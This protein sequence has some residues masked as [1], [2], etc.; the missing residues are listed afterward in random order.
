MKT[1]LAVKHPAPITAE[2]AIAARIGPEQELRRTVA[3]CMLWEDGFY[4]SGAAIGDRIKSL[5]PKCRPE[6]VAACAFEARTKMKLRHAPLLLV[7]EMARSAEHRVLVSKLLPDV[8][9]RADE[10]AEF[11][12]LYWKDGKQPLSKQVKTGLAQAFGKF[13]EYQLAKY[14]RDGAVKLR[15]VLFLCHAKA[16]N[17]EQ[18]ALW[19]KLIDGKLETPDTWEVALSGG[20]DKKATFERLMVEGQLGALAFLR[21]LR[22]MREAGVSADLVT[23][24][25][26]AVDIARVLPFRF[27]AAARAVPAWENILEPM[28]LRACEGREKLAGRTIVL[29]DVSGSMDAA[30]S[31]KSDIQRIDAACGV[32]ILLRELCEDVEVITFSRQVVQVAPRRGFALRDAI[33]ASQPHSSTYLGQAVELVNRERQYDRLVVLTDEQS[34]DRVPAPKGKGYVINVASNKNGVGYGPWNHIDGWS[35]AVIDYVQEFERS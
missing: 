29:L 12:S 26:S 3:A 25:A 16:Q 17:P 28:M 6:F 4:E 7:R 19:K 13:N 21:N 18:E 27:L 30:I 20:A 9:Q 2:G 1:N 34:A 14:N 15:D 31:G 5:V 23:G 35:E 22:N 33:V 10:L 24:Y 8:I 11:V 32:A